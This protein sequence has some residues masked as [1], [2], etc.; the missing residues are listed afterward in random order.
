MSVD[1]TDSMRITG[2]QQA[3][4]DELC[5]MFPELS[6]GELRRLLDQ[7]KG[8]VTLVIDKLLG[9]PSPPNSTTATDQTLTSHITMGNPALSSSPASKSTFEPTL[10]PSISDLPQ[11]Q[12]AHVSY[13]SPW[14]HPS[15]AAEP[16][17][18]PPAA[19][20]LS[21]H[22]DPNLSNPSLLA[23]YSS[24]IS[25]LRHGSEQK[26]SEIEGPQP[27][28]SLS[29]PRYLSSNGSD[30]T[31]ISHPI[32]PNS[33]SAVQSPTSTNT[34]KVVTQ[35]PQLVEISSN[36][37]TTPSSSPTHSFIPIS[38]IYDASRAESPPLAATLSTP[39]SISHIVRGTPLSTSSSPVHGIPHS[40]HTPGLGGSMASSRTSEERAARL[41]AT[42][43]QFQMLMASMSELENTSQQE[44]E[45]K[46][47]RIMQL[48]SELQT[49]NSSKEEWYSK[50]QTLS[51][52][53]LHLREQFGQQGTLINSLVEQSKAKDKQ[54]A[55]LQA[56]LASYQPFEAADALRSRFE[57]SLKTLSP[58]QDEEVQNAMRLFAA[59]FQRAFASALLSSSPPQEK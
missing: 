17:F 5:G 28:R 14:G 25:I 18:P 32:I 42:E 13:D 12:G 37:R 44:L 50:F 9:Q 48:E 57:S 56:K 1:A 30:A 41:R 53:M 27:P 46:E 16:R 6:M 2:D 40:P 36:A 11:Q 33:S 20:E 39:S 19:P 52:N 29:P 38:H 55:D 22:V 31:Q 24:P 35:L 54:I 7:Y 34:N 47:A 8:D 21:H 49:L 59:T 15:S 4:L 3:T 45:Q 26:R 23:S 43:A 51:N 10:T 58:S